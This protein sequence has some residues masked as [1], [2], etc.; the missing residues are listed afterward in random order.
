[1]SNTVPGFFD[2]QVNG[3]LGVNFSGADLTPE[4]AHRAC[5]TV[6]ERGTVGFLPTM[7]TAARETYRRNLPLLAD[8]VESS[9]FA[10][11]LPGIHA[12][13][14][15]LSPEPG[16][17]GAHRVEWMKPPDTGL[18]AEMQDW[19]RGHIRLLTI[20]A[21][22]PGAPELV[23]TAVDMGIVVGL[24]H[25]LAGL[26]DLRRCADAG[27]G[28]LTH[29][30]NGIP[31]QVNRHENPIWAG[32]AETRLAVS[33]V[34][35]GHHLPEA[36][37]RSFVL[38]AGPERLLVVSDASSMA[39]MPPGRYEALG[40][41][42]EINEAGRL[43]NPSTGYLVGSWCNILQ[44]MNHLASLG[45]LDLDGL[46]RVGLHGPLSMLGMHVD[47]LP[48]GPG[49]LWCEETMQFCPA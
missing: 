4:D 21:D 15:F 26:D 25:H 49:L 32:L 41:E 29:L 13:G 6:L 22:Q 17:A 9:E 45:M 8:L 1:M 18:L 28:L 37:L 11:R 23:R 10:R 42:V 34:A 16:A 44:C 19:A 46:L 7:V 31:L 40:N 47:D 14:P 36:I 12:E 35:D 20:A 43:Y 30:G 24:G 48:A 5:R 2:L 27:A 38:A 33:I 39:G 3:H